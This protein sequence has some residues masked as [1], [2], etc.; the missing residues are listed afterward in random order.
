MA[1]TVALLALA[2]GLSSLQVGI[3]AIV[4]GM[5]RLTVLLRAMGYDQDSA[6]GLLGWIVGRMGYETAA[7]QSLTAYNSV[8]LE[9][10]QAMV[11]HWRSLALRAGDGA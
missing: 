11:A 7:L 10:A 9:D 2:S 3:M 8:S 1:V 6:G 4:R 5:P